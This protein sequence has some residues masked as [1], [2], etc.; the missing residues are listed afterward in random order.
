MAALTWLAYALTRQS[1]WPALVSA[2]QVLPMLVLGVWGGGLA[3]RWPKRWLIFLTQVIF[4]L[5]ALLLA[6]LVVA[7]L[8]TPEALL[9]VSLLI[10]VVNA[11]DSPA[12]LAFVID[13]VGRDDLMNAVALNSMIFNVARAVGPAVGAL[14]LR[15]F[16]FAGCF[17]VNALTFLAVLAGLAAMH[18]PGLTGDARR[19][20]LPASFL[21][22]F[23][24]LGQQPAQLLLLAL[25]GVIAFF[26]WPLLSLLPALSDKQLE[27]GGDGY[28]WM[29]SGVGTGAL[30][31][32]LLIATFGQPQRRRG[33]LAAGVIVSVAAQL[34]LANVATLL[35]AVVGCAMS[36]CGLILFFTTGQAVIQLGA[37]EH[38]RGR[39]MGIWLMVLA[40]AQ[41]AGNLLAGLVADKFGV[42][43]TLLWQATGITVASVVVLVVAL[44][45]GVRPVK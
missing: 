23:R 30:I 21:D 38:N 18:L 36:G 40:G 19:P 15:E 12:R 17:L 7:G 45:G 27:T 37:D 41:P 6:G 26:G 2:A 10:G 22:G 43:I 4:L 34:I 42:P 44:V 32:A 39:I 8:I 1:R 13:L 14:M 35:P 16:G 5:L 25:A 3:D 31:G 9:A 28:A 11:V 20:T 29:L 33:F 24:H